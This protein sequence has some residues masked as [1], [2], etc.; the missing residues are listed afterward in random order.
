MRSPYAYHRRATRAV[1]TIGHD[2]VPRVV[3]HLADVSITKMEDL[4]A[5][6]HVYDATTDKW[7]MRDQ[8]AEFLYMGATPL[9]FMA[10]SGTRQLLD[11]DVWAVY[12]EQFYCVP[13]FSIDAYRSATKHHP[14]MN[15]V[16]CT[17]SELSDHLVEYLASDATVVVLLSS[18]APSYYTNMRA[19]ID[20]VTELGLTA[21]IILE[22]D[23]RSQS[24]DVCV[25]YASTDLG[26]LFVDGMG[27]GTM[28]RVGTPEMVDL[29]QSIRLSFTILQAT[30]TRMTKT[31]Y[32]SCPSCGRTL[33]DLQETTARIRAHTDHL[34]GVKI[35]I[36]GCIV[37]GPGEMADADYGYVGSGPDRITLY[38][39]QEIVQRNIPS[40]GAV[41]ALI[42]IIRSDDR[43]VEPTASASKGRR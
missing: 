42:E 1:A 8:A 27:D 35:G 29:A 13:V 23:I 32:I 17:N 7:A 14:V 20:H 31:E 16:R 36:M 28:L 9:P 40:D 5:I 11:A 19:T 10:P 22:H 34:K 38:R 39:G 12:E 24:I 30:R 25:L 41:D 3:A 15:V 26:G 2:H 6:G 37:N 18:N 43:W 33:F 4:A 21:P